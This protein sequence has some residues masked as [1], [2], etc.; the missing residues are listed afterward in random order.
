MIQWD[1]LLL[2]TFDSPSGSINSTIKTCSKH[3]QLEETE[4]TRMINTCLKENSLSQ[5]HLF[6]QL[7]FIIFVLSVRFT[8]MFQIPGYTLDKLCI[9][10]LFVAERTV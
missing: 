5:E 8:P 10:I 1:S 9:F 4:T 7:S 3:N 6:F 2:P